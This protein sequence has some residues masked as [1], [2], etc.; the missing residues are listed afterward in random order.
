VPKLDTKV[1]VTLVTQVLVFLAGLTLSPEMARYVIVSLTTIGSAFV[2]VRGVADIRQ[3]AKA[4]TAKG[5]VALLAFLVSGA[6][7]AV[8]VNAL[9]C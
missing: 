6:S 2:G 5:L 3:P 7:G 8:Y 9:V 1:L 4:T